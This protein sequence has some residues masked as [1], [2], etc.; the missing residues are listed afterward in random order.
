MGFSTCENWPLTERLGFL[1]QIMSTLK[2]SILIMK[3]KYSLFL[4]LIPFFAIS[5]IS[6]QKTIFNQEL[7]NKI[8]TIEFGD[9]QILELIKDTNNKITGALINSV[10]KLKKKEKRGEIITQKTV[11]LNNTATELFT[12]LE[13]NNF[14]KISDCNCDG[15]DGTTTTFIT[16]TRDFINQSYYWELESDYYKKDEVQSVKISE[17]R[18]LTSSIAK[19][20]DVE[21]SFKTFLSTLPKGKYTY[22]MIIM[23]KK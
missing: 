16:Q 5:Q 19:Y 4:L 18:K 22:G 13:K 14:D 15:L 23:E 7:H 11:L 3:A 6:I 2:K 12:D 8:Y 1:I 20:V 17:A 9:C 10:W 21:L